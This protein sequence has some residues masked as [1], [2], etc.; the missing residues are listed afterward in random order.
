MNYF[1]SKKMQNDSRWFM[2]CL[3]FVSFLLLGR[4][5]F[6]SWY[7]LH[8]VIIIVLLFFLV[9]VIKKL[10]KNKEKK[11]AC[12]WDEFKKKY[13]I[14]MQYAPVEW[15][16]PAEAWLLYNLRVE[17]TDL[18]SLIYRWEFEWLIQIETFKWKN[19][20]KEYVKLIKKDE[21][22]LTCPSFESEIFD[23]IF[24]MWDVKI[25]EESF[26]LK[27]ALMLEDLE[28]HW[29]RKWWIVRSNLSKKWKCFHGALSFLLFLCVLL[30]LLD[31]YVIFSII[32]WIVFWALLLSFIV[33]SWYIYWWWNFVFTDKWAEL[34]SKIIW[35][36][37][38]IKSCDENKIK[39]F[40]K[41]DPLFIDRT[42]P[43]ATAFGMET[44]FL[45]KIS[46]LKS[47]W[48]AKYVR[49]KKVPTRS[50]VLRMMIWSNE[51][52]YF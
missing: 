47:D 20:N 30:V 12:L 38:F 32:F 37:N 28:Y 17:P 24:A 41:Q 52:S 49:W 26:Q 3:I 40:L 25:I 4:E 6:K 7:L 31:V 46:P 51:D 48:N 16:N 29:I 27:Y 15:I 44:E 8:V 36:R 14:I 33:L 39:L 10:K 22:S 21:L 42:L 11:P 18:T 1:R 2:I 43:F 5:I 9:L 34:A 13:P 45:R 35:Y 50:K 23:S 19:S